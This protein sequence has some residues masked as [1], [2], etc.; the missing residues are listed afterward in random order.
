MELIRTKMQSE[1]LKYS[2]IGQ[3]IK[4]SIDNYG[5]KSLYR[6]L[7]KFKF[8]ILIIHLFIFKFRFQQSGEMFHLA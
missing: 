6:G 3:A 2:Q 7:V 1:R 5:F 8:F 4:I